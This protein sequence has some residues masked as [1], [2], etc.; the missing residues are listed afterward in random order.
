MKLCTVAHEE[1]VVTMYRQAVKEE[2]RQIREGRAQCK[3][4]LH[5]GASPEE[6]L[7]C[8][9]QRYVELEREVALLRTI[10]LRLFSEPSNCRDADGAR[11]GNGSV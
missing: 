1:D 3:S 4:T 11:N 2:M 8:L 6:R 7:R 10:V 9:T 5:E